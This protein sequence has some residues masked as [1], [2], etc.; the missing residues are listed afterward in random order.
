MLI[1]SVFFFKR[2]LC[3]RTFIDKNEWFEISQYT[4]HDPAI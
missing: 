3:N 4:H 2:K 1:R